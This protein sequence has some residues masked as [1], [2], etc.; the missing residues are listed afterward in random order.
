MGVILS[1]VQD[2][3]NFKNF[4]DSSG[5]EQLAKQFF[6][7]TGEGA[8]CMPIDLLAANIAGV[9]DGANVTIQLVFD[10]GDGQLYQVTHS[11]C[12]YMQYTY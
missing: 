7:T 10:G 8:F 9:K 2:P 12:L 5:N 6:E 4:T 1:T 3:N 11:L